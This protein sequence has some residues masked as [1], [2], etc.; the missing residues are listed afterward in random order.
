MHDADQNR[1]KGVKEAEARPGFRQPGRG[2]EAIAVMLLDGRVRV[3]VKM[4][5]VVML[6]DVRMRSGDARVSRGEFFAEPF[7]GSGEIENAE[8]DQHQAHGEFH[9]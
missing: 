4:Q 7:H 1:T 2:G 5:V 6:M 8:Q 3:P 9:G